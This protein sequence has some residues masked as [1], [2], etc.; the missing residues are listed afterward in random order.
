MAN[1]EM[2]RQAFTSAFSFHEAAVRCQDSDPETGKPSHVTSILAPLATCISF[3]AELYMKSILLRRLERKVVMRARHYLDKLFDML[4]KDER[5][6]VLQEV[7]KQDT[8]PSDQLPQFLAHVADTFVEWRYIYEQPTIVLDT[9]LLFMFASAL[10]RA[11]R[12]LEP[13]W[14]VPNDLH[15][16]ITVSESEA[17]HVHVGPDLQLPDFLV[18]ILRQI[19]IPHT[20]FAKFKGKYFGQTVPANYFKQK[21]PTFQ[22]KVGTGSDPENS[23]SDKSG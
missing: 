13:Q 7:E 19:G 16:R 3:A 18:D 9:G 14:A 10:Y 12:L 1:P 17:L 22:T 20:N 2:A 15:E 5:E 6:I 21:P 23:G 4:D 8:L 11:A